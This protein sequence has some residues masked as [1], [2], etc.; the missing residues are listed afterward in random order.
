MIRKAE[1]AGDDAAVCEKR[2]RPTGKRNEARSR[3]RDLA[4]TGMNAERSTVWWVAQRRIHR[5]K[6]RSAPANAIYSRPRARA[7]ARSRPRASSVLAYE[8]RTVHLRGFIGH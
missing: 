3:G 5:A 6:L 4:E 7:R 1:R 8:N 2:K